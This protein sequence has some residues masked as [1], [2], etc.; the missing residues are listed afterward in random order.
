[1]NEPG[2]WMADMIGRNHK[3]RQA[4]TAT[5]I[6]AGLLAA[7]TPAWAQGPPAYNETFKEHK[8]VIVL[9]GM[10]DP[11]TKEV[12]TVTEI[13]N[14]SA[15]LTAAGV[16]GDPSE[17]VPAWT[18]PFK[19]TVSFTNHLIFVPDDPSRPTYEGHSH[20]HLSYVIKSADGLGTGAF[21]NQIILKGSDGSK[22]KWHETARGVLS[23]TEGII[24]TIRDRPR[25]F[26]TT[27]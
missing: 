10:E 13:E 16:I 20:T 11:C 4:A 25:C 9:Q 18:A 1:M 12:G 19:Y 24:E 23:P 5:V 7:G 3:L 22:I 21:E 26:G 17:G 2:R 27:S 8:E 14:A 15:H 6:T